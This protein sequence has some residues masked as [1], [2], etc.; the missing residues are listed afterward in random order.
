M[1]LDCFCEFFKSAIEFGKSMYMGGGKGGSEGQ[2]APQDNRLS[3]TN[4]NADATVKTIGLHMG[5]RSIR[6]ET[7]V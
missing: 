2:T 3:K 4:N 6:E 5:T 1:R 7:C